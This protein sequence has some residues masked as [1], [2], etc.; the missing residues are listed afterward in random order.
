MN[1]DAIWDGEWGQSR[2]GCI[3]GGDRRRGSSSFG[4]EFGASHCNQLGLFL[5]SCAEVGEPIEL[6]FGEVSGVGPDIR[7]LDGDFLAF[8]PHWFEWAECHIFHTEM[9]STCT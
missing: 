6:S 7:V 5:R 8:V 2:D 4:G 1:P 9:Y 3:G